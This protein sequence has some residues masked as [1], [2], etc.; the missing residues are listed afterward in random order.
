MSDTLP[1]FPNIDSTDWSPPAPTDPIEMVRVTKPLIIYA[2]ANNPNYQ[3][4]VWD[5]PRASGWPRLNNWWDNS[6]PQPHQLVLRKFWKLV[7]GTFTH[8]YPGT[9]L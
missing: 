9:H 2:D 3:D 8:L 7:P 4:N 6:A 1:A 5:E